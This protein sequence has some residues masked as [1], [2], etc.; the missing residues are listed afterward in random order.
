MAKKKTEELKDGSKSSLSL[1]NGRTFYDDYGNTSA[2]NYSTGKYD[3]KF[4]GNALADNGWR[5]TSDYYTPTQNTP[6]YELSSYNGNLPT[7]NTSVLSAYDNISA[8]A[9]Q[10]YTSNPYEY[11]GTQFEYDPYSYDDTSGYLADMLTKKDAKDNFTYDA[12]SD[13][14]YQNYKEQYTRN[15]QNAMN[16][17]LGQIATRTGGIA[18]TYAQTAAAQQYNAYMQELANKIPELSQLAYDKVYQNY[19]DAYNL[20]SDDE[21]RQYRDYSD[22][23]NTAYNNWQY[24]EDVNQN[25]YANTWSNTNEVNANNIQLQNALA[26]AEYQRQLA[27]ADAA[28]E[29]EN[30]RYN[31]ELSA[32]NND[33]D[34]YYK[35]QQ[36]QLDYANTAAQNQ[37]KYDAEYKLKQLEAQNDATT[38]KVDSYVK[39]ASN[40][41]TDEDKVDYV[42]GLYESDAVDY[43]TA[44]YILRSSGVSESAIRN[45]IQ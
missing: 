11:V 16:D 41:Y 27:A 28:V 32:Y 12:E 9:Y 26:D 38:K 1:S 37:A 6:T 13:P 33:M 22:L 2:Y 18:S 20:Y 42:A 29:A 5:T 21:S 35:M 10:T 31:G 34:N 40:K 4:T 17:T 24:N 45:M 7:Y 36:S 8:P 39:A 43:D 25:N 14:L 23:K 19:S 3:D 44:L 30:T 15:G